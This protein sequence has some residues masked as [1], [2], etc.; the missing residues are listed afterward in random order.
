MSAN[1]DMLIL[2]RECR[3]LT[4]KELSAALGIQQGTVSKMEAGLLPPSDETLDRYGRALDFPLEFFFQSDRVFGFNST[5]FYHRKRQALPD[6]ALRRLHA[7]M[8]LTRMRVARLLRSATLVVA[9][10]F[11]RLEIAE[12]KSAEE[13]ARLARSMWMVPPGP[14]KSV[15]EIIESAGGVVVRF[16]FGTK[17]IDAISEWVPG[18]PPI[19]LINSDPAITGDRLRLTLAHEVGHILMHAFPSPDMEDEANQFAAEFLMPRREIK[20]SLY[21]L[22]MAKLMQLKRIWKVSMQALVVRAY[23]LKTITETQ[24]RYMFMNFSKRGYRTREPIETDVP[25]ERPET[26]T[27]LARAHLQDLGFSIRDVMKLL[28]YCDE[29][30]FRSVYL[31]GG[32]LQLV[33]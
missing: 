3:G 11:R 1:A 32:N 2:A 26:M 15:I 18:Y 9:E 17:Q 14:I 6:K 24:R 27:K 31:G 13:I 19:F 5:V 4:Q 12:F 29:A 33:G 16:D 30:E 20:A 28:F 22:N 10:G 7:Y 25:I 23:E 21:G 8:N